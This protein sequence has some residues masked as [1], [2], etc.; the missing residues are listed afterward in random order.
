[1]V[2]LGWVMDGWQDIG[3]RRADTV[4]VLSPLRI[5]SRPISRQDGWSSRICDRADLERTLRLVVMDSLRL[6]YIPYIDVCILR[7]VSTVIRTSRRT[8]RASLPDIEFCSL[9]FWVPVNTFIF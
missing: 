1:M 2:V 4:R 7:W 5:F 8:K 6:L 3:M 9:T